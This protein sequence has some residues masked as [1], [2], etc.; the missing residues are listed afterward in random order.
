VLSVG[1]LLGVI[2]AAR[3]PIDRSRGA[4]NARGGEKLPARL[5]EPDTKNAV[6]ASQLALLEAQVAG[7]QAQARER[8]LQA[9][10]ADPADVGAKE[11]PPEPAPLDGAAVRFE[12]DQEFE[13][14]ISDGSW[15][16]TES[17]ALRAFIDENTKGGT[18]ESLE[19]RSSMCRVRM[20]FEKP[21]DRRAFMA[22]V[23][24]PRFENAS[25]MSTDEATGKL[26]LFTARHGENLPEL[27]SN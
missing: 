11:A 24:S 20:S 10:L 2:V 7:L 16:T 15:A 21:S 18:V 3:W 14:Q 8:A 23:G 25:F 5:E 17:R 6:L 9:R 22:S 1:A 27:A 13:R 19:C 26:T 4:S 12:Y